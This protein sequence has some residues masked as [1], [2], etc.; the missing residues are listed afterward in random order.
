MCAQMSNIASKKHEN[1]LT[2]HSREGGNP[3]LLAKG[4]L[5]SRL[6]GNVEL[7]VSQSSLTECELVLWNHPENGYGLTRSS[8]QPVRLLLFVTEE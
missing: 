3:V 2:R 6:R 5:D 7:F 8:L 4:L 1:P